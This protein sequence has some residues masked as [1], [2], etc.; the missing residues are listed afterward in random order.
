VPALALPAWRA[1]ILLAADGPL[2]AA[3]GGQAIEFIPTVHPTELFMEYIPPANNSS[4]VGSHRPTRE[5][6]LFY[7]LEVAL[8]KPGAN[9]LELRNDTD[10]PVEVTRI[11]L[12][13]W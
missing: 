7:R 3:L 6:S 11:N 1:R 4:N 8:L 2:A 12:G 5:P 9:T 10:N 13:L